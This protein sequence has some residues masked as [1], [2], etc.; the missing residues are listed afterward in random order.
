ML[1]FNLIQI[2]EVITTEEA[3]GL[4]QFH[5]EH[6]HLLQ[7]DPSPL[8]D[9][10]KIPMGHIQTGWIRTL[11][12]KLEYLSIAEIASQTGQ[13]VYPEQTEIMKHPN[14]SEIPWHIDVYDTMEGDTIVPQT[15]WAGVMYLNDD[16]SGGKLQFKPC[17]SLP[18]GFEYTPI[19]CELVLFQGMDFHHSV[20]KVYRNDRYTLPLW[21]TTNLLDMRPDSK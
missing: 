3:K 11:M 18:M 4:I 17:E 12:R 21:F 7:E 20:S 19:A 8:Y 9:R 15:T 6:P 5:K 14:G 16:Y 1:D 2:P 10:R 13:K